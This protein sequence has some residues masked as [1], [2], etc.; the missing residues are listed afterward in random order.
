MRQD[1]NP[2]LFALSALFSDRSLQTARIPL[3]VL[4][5]MALTLLMTGCGEDFWKDIKR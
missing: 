2:G 4:W 5:Y 3:T 1:L